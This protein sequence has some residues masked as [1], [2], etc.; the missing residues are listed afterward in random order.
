MAAVGGAMDGSYAERAKK[1][2]VQSSF[3]NNIKPRIPHDAIE[4]PSASTSDTLDSSP[5]HSS[6][7]T[8][9]TNL[10]IP[11]SIPVSSA[12][13]ENTSPL[14]SANPLPPR[15]A[16]S[17]RSPWRTPQ[18]P[19]RTANPPSVVTN[20][21]AIHAV[22]ESSVHETQHEPRSRL[23]S[24][25]K[26]PT[27]INQPNDSDPFV[28][29]YNLTSS[30][31]ADAQNWPQV[32][33]ATTSVSSPHHPKSSL[34][35]V[36]PTTMMSTSHTP[37]KTGHEGENDGTPS[38][39]S[40]GEKTKW[41]AIPPKEL[42]AAADEA[43]KR[44]RPG[45]TS[46]KS[47]S[48]HINGKGTRSQDENF[49]GRS[50]GRPVSRG[51]G[52]SP[53]TAGNTRH[54]RNPSLTVPST[55]SS[56]RVS[57]LNL[58]T[59]LPSVSNNATVQPTLAPESPLKPRA[60]S[61]SHA[62][63][64][65]ATSQQ[66]GQNRP[67]FTFV[68]PVVPLH[69]PNRPSNHSRNPSQNPHYQP[70][71]PMY[72]PGWPMPVYMMP[73]YPQNHYHYIPPSINPP[74]IASAQAQTEV[75]VSRSVRLKRKERPRPK[76]AV[77]LAGYRSTVAET[78]T[79]Q[80]IGHALI[81][82]TGEEEPNIAEIT[83]LSRGDDSHSKIQTRDSW[84]SYGVDQQLILRRLKRQPAL[85]SP[86]LTGQQLSE[87]PRINFE[88]EVESSKSTGVDS[89]I[90]TAIL[91]GANPDMRSAQQPIASTQS[92][93]LPAPGA[94]PSAHDIGLAMGMPMPIPPM[95]MHPPPLLMGMHPPPPFLPSPASAAR[96]DWAPRDDL[97]GSAPSP[98]Y[99]YPYPPYGYPPMN[100]PNGHNAGY[101]G[102]GQ[103]RGTSRWRDERYPPRG[104]RG[105]GFNGRG[106]GFRG[107]T[108]P[109]SYNSQVPPSPGGSG[110]PAYPS[111][112]LPTSAAV[113]ISDPVM[114]PSM[115]PY[116]NTLPP[117]PFNEY[118][119]A[120]E[121]P[122]A[123][124]NDSQ[125]RPPSPKPLTQL[126]FHLDNTQFKLLGQIEYY[127]SR[128]NV[129]KD[130]YL[131]D[132]MDSKG[133]V[134]I[135]VLQSFPRIKRLNVSDDQIRET[136]QL[137]QFVEVQYNHLRMARE[138]WRNF[139]LPTATESSVPDAH[140]LAWYPPPFHPGYMPMY[141]HLPQP[142]PY[143]QPPQKSSPLLQ[144][145]VADHILRRPEEK[146]FNGNGNGV[147]ESGTSA[148]D[149]FDST[150]HTEGEETSEDDVVFLIGDPQPMQ[151]PAPVTLNP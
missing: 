72:T 21:P 16:W 14:P 64:H 129:A 130:K 13:S 94:G 40:K 1:A 31:L 19:Q 70:P 150:P 10:I 103:N 108:N 132:R 9:A 140:P 61:P 121:A 43:T 45:S 75:A 26:A 54:D 78:L 91:N 7:N 39:K 138:D 141:P 134:P 126:N 116:S 113:Y 85:K 131:R 120:P 128:D 98:S 122:A 79:P 4:V 56:R 112:H 146:V 143:P 57:P 111:Q 125:A 71:P 102:D 115:Y 42:Q 15:N 142:Y 149:S 137:S 73:Y 97:Y 38:K 144:G 52:P 81:F 104:G 80:V 92:S 17:D 68:E 88:P 20:G 123:P 66:G 2:T 124:I 48:P 136:L 28:V 127:F 46:S 148:G 106:R 11:P 8:P 35:S 139:V 55:T 107:L 36:T 41:V 25:A 100:P 95:G 110:Q 145:G 151:R 109:R 119:Q 50:G 89:P 29:N 44:S 93:N 117:S 37:A 34:P 86:L 53:I 87:G 58:T 114:H 77:P 32:G 5:A 30:S 67:S 69:P 101:S 59:S 74:T 118:P 147:L 6:V 90:E 60:P 12:S 96:M 62:Q 105:R 49:E 47:H 82:H 18:K 83:V 51:D 24:P 22:L 135:G 23:T 33:I 27:K 3:R 76:D 63:L 133:W 65:N 99:P 84:W